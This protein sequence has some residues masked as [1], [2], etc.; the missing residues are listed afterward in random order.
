MGISMART[1]KRTSHEEADVIITQRAVHA[2]LNEIKSVKVICDDTDVF[3][4]LVYVYYL[5]H[6]KATL[7]VE[8]TSGE[9]TVIDIGAT[10]TKHQTIIPNLLATH[11]LTGYDTVARFAGIGK[12]KAIK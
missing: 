1:D 12:V 7:L 10:A 6:L 4:L 9:R 11:V 2:A 3:V 8:S 5:E